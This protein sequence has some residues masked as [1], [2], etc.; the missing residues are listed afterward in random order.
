MEL[1][2]IAEI[3]DSTLAGVQESAHESGRRIGVFENIYIW[4]DRAYKRAVIFADGA[5]TVLV[6]FI[7][8][9]GGLLFRSFS[10]L[11][12][13]FLDRSPLLIKAPINFFIRI[14]GVA[15]SAVMFLT[16]S[17]AIMCVGTVG[18]LFGFRRVG[19]YSWIEQLAAWLPLF[20]FIAAVPFV[21]SNYTLFKVSLVFAYAIGVLGL[22]FLYGNCGIISLGHSGFVLLGGYMA[23]WLVNGQFGFSTPVIVGV[24][25][26]GLSMI[27]LGV[28][29]GAPSLRIKDYYLVIMT[30]GFGFAIPKVLK[31]P[32]LKEYSGLRE[33]G[34]YI[35]SLKPFG[36]FSSLKPVALSYYVVAAS[37]LVLFYLAYN[38]VHHSQIGRAFKMIKCD[39]EISM[40][41]GVPVVRYKLLAFALSAIYAA[42]C[43]GFLTVLTKFIHPDSYPMHVSIDFLVANVIGGPG[44]LLGAIFGGIFMAFEPDIALRMA[45]VI[46]GGKDLASAFYGVILILAIFFV[47]YGISGE[48]SRRLKARFQS[49]G[50]RGLYA[51]SPPPDYDY[52]EEDKKMI[53]TD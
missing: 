4:T 8:S 24:L 31:S 53:P 2:E 40:I 29:M 42:F 22:D 13:Q 26:A 18:G 7:G 48:I 28:I 21:V 10:S 33:G 3:K 5:F 32:Y 50:R 43:G 16:V 27:P 47:P 11:L 9:V 14:I 37:A 6:L 41:M 51:F 38:I 39:N 19:E 23:T 49:M 20:L 44:T 1:T 46:P 52:L 36:F 35:N 17:F 12:T 15:L 34:L 45:H 30:M 25:L